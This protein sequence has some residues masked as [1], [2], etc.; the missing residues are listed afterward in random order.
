MKVQAVYEIEFER[1]DPSEFFFTSI[2]PR[3][4]C[5]GQFGVLRTEA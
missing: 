2:K 4:H 3:D 5:V 1:E